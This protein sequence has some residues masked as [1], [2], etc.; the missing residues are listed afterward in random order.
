MGKGNDDRNDVPGCVAR[1]DRLI[2]TVRNAG[3]VP[4]IKGYRVVKDTRVRRQGAISTYER[5]RELRSADA[6]ADA[7]MFIQYQPLQGFLPDQRVTMVGDDELGITPE[8]IDDIIR[9]NFRAHK[10]SL[11]ELALDFTEASGVDENFVRRFGKFGN[12]RR[13]KDRGGP[14]TLRYG[15]RTSP[16]LVRCYR[17]KSLDS[18]R[19]ELEIHSA[20]LRKYAITNAGQLYAIAY[21]LASRHVRFVR[22]DWDKLAPAL[23]RRFGAGSAEILT[24][25]RRRADVSLGSATRYL[26]KRLP[27]VHRYFKPL[28]INRDVRTALKR[29][30]EEF[31]PLESFFPVAN[32]ASGGR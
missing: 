5:V 32:D 22:V 14:D 16:K 13:R 27:N 18:Y 23:Q 17:K 8:E 25:S 6:D 3:E 31:Y 10:I 1:L 28:R 12:T 2:L 7:Q 20:L 11:A 4:A 26:G 24:E 30:A 9:V 19:V 21:K 29:W 15:S